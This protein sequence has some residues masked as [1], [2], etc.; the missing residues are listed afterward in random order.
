MSK[1]EF[2]DRLTNLFKLMSEDLETVQRSDT[3]MYAVK[4]QL[5]RMR[6]RARYTK[7]ELETKC[8]IPSKNLITL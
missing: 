8:L 1:L 7:R 5:T 4:R 2:E 6:K 3:E